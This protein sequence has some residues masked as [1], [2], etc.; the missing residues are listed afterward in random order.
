MIQELIACLFS[1]A[2]AVVEHRRCMKMHCGRM[3]ACIHDFFVT[4]L[5]A[6][7]AMIHLRMVS[8]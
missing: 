1:V 2:I 6:I 5:S 8:H 4:R 7:G 3:F